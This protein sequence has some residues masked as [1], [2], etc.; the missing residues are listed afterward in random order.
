[1]IPKSA[2]LVLGGERVQKRVVLRNRTLCDR[3]RP[4]GIARSILVEA[5]PVLRQARLIS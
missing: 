4:V 2:C 3:R 1:M 5:V